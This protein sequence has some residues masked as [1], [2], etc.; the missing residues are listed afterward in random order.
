MIK[1]KSHRK[2]TLP[3]ETARLRLRDFVKSDR[4]A[5]CAFSS[6][7]RVTKYLFFGPRDEDSAADYLEGLLASQSEL[8]RTRFEL[9]VEERSTDRA[10]AFFVSRRAGSSCIPA[11]TPRRPL[12]PVPGPS[13]WR[14]RAHPCRACPCC[15]CCAG[16]GGPQ[17]GR[18]RPGERSG[19]PS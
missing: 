7:A 12:R 5:V 10:D 16:S 11:R 3:I 4:G 19:R 8:P 17:P 15:G 1:P 6:D 14:D 9:A 13:P 18:K 2:L